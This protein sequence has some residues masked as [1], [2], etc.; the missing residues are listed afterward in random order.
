[1]QARFVLFQVDWKIT[2][3]DEDYLEAA[4]DGAVR[5][6][7]PSVPE[8]QSPPK[9]EEPLPAI[10]RPPKLGAEPK[11]D[12]DLMAPEEGSSPTAKGAAAGRPAKAP[13]PKIAERPQGAPTAAEP[14]KRATKQGAAAERAAQK[15]IVASAAATPGVPPRP[16]IAEE[17]AAEKPAPAVQPP[18]TPVPALQRPAS[19]PAMAEPLRA[20]AAADAQTSATGAFAAPVAS[21]ASSAA[22]NAGELRVTPGAVE[23]VSGGGTADVAARSAG[24]EEDMSSSSAAAGAAAGQG[25][26]PQ[27]AVARQLTDSKAVR[28]RG[29]SVEAKSSAAPVAPLQQSLSPPSKPVRPQPVPAVS[30][31]DIHDAYDAAMAAFMAQQPLPGVV[32]QV[33]GTSGVIVRVQG[34]FQGFL[35]WSKLLARRQAGLLERERASWAAMQPLEDKSEEQ[36]AR[37]QLRRSIMGTIV[38]QRVMVYVHQVQPPPEGSNKVAKVLLSERGPVYKPD[39][40]IPPYASEV[41]EQKLG[42]CVECTVAK[43][44]RYGAFLNFA[45]EVAHG[46]ICEIY[47][48]MHHSKMGCLA[49]EPLQEGQDVTAYIA[50]VDAVNGRVQ[51]S[52]EPPKAGL[53][54]NQTL[55]D[56]L[57]QG[58]SEGAQSDQKGEAMPEAME[59]CRELLLAGAITEAQPGRRLQGRA[60]S[61]EVQVFMAKGPEEMD[62]NDAVGEVKRYTLL[63]R[64]RNEVQ[65]IDMESALDREQMKTALAQALSMVLGVQ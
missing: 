31:D 1:M 38:E 35:P 47:G 7:A 28:A 14:S 46:C 17:A 48:L 26:L 54:L 11:D 44:T 43:L 5:R 60:F 61:P 30:R 59:V 64:A 12:P 55:E 41:L 13:S 52:A 58:T 57:R 63:A 49:A 20:A 23:A 62:S 19:A 37:A 56:L 2:E 4:Q 16:S 50:E 22:G 40:G 3:I 27:Q 51:L 21:S 18:A 39:M 9:P 33:L 8:K 34:K 42:E 10:V 6:P 36:T 45:V 25:E 32:L 24:G 29:G 53:P 65:E 15:S